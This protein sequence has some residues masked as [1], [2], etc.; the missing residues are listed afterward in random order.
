MK[1]ATQFRGSLTDMPYEDKLF[2]V[3]KIVDKVI[4]TKEQVKICGRIPVLEHLVGA[5][6][7]LYVDNRYSYE[8][9]EL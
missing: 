9:N 2:T 8:I 1:P 6:V 7:G 5:Q 4:A 3:R